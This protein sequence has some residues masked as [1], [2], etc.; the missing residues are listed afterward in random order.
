MAMVFRL[1]IYSGLVWRQRLN[2]SRSG[3]GLLAAWVMAETGFAFDCDHELIVDKIAGVNG[4]LFDFRLKCVFG[5]VS[6]QHHCATT[7]ERNVKRECAILEDGRER[8]GGFVAGMP[9]GTM[10][11]NESGKVSD[12]DVG[13]FMLA[14]EGN[15]QGIAA[16]NFKQVDLHTGG[17]G[18]DTMRREHPFLAAHGVEQRAVVAE[19][20]VCRRRRRAFSG[21]ASPADYSRKHTTNGRAYRRSSSRR[22]RLCCWSGQASRAGQCKCRMNPGSIGGAGQP[23]PK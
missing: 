7:L 20:L 6:Q 13:K 15:G 17:R 19:G 14:A 21:R 11:S 10:N 5:P 3:V 9:R 1:D 23:A 8:R 16:G 12:N 22:R 2:S 4:F 18:F